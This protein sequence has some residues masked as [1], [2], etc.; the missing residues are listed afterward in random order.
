MY[1]ECGLICI[2]SF[3]T[4][5]RKQREIVQY[6]SIHITLIG[7]KGVLARGGGGGLGSNYAGCVCPKVKDMRSFFTF[8]GVK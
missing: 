6:G 3:H 5:A 1:T 2:G 4:Q 7:H 8:K